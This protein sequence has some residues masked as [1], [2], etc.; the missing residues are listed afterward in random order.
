MPAKKSTS[1]KELNVY[2]VLLAGGSG[3]RLW[4]ISR[5]LYPKQLVNLVGDDSLVQNTI[6]RLSPVLKTAHVRI[7]CGD[8]H[9]FEIARHLEELDIPSGDKVIAEPCGRNTA[10]AILLAV[11]EILKKEKD[12][13]IL[14]FPSDHVISDLEEFHKQLQTAISL[15]K[16]DYIVTFGIQPDYPETGYGYIE[17][18]KKIK[19]GALAIKRFVEKPDE[20]TA[21]NYLK[22]GN[23]FWNSGMFAFKASALVKEFRT[24]EPEMLKSLQ[25]MVSKGAVTLADYSE[26]PDKSIDYAIMEKTKKGVVLPSDF[27]WSDIGSWKSLY[28]FLPKGDGENV[29]EGD[30]ICQNTTNCFI[31]G[32]NRLVVANDL[33]NIVIVETPDT[34]FVSD[35]EQ[36][37]N[38]KTIVQDLKRHGRKEY[39]SHVTVYRPW[40][41]YTILEENSS[42]KIKRIVVYPGAKLS[43]Q[44]HYHRSEHW[45]VAQGTARITNGDNVVVLKENEST[46]VPKATRH[47]LENPGRI[48]LHIIEVQMG[49][50]LEEDDIVRYDDD[51]G[52]G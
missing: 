45:I 34:V 31:R 10:P 33:Q 52:R 43:L 51:F 9:F 27:G 7:V 29:I 8:D 18:A 42:S 15:A 35:L 47:R 48:P 3:S 1:K 14:I 23:F 37:K 24:F 19:G 11:L 32:D 39:K 21:K 38:V 16:A 13:I 28:D 25:A 50:Y 44:M 17:G 12:A 30:V 5:E 22:A 20:R 2:P 41:T 49:H 36:S 6:R 40:G 26:L 46:F 4:P